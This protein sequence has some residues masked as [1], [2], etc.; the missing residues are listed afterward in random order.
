MFLGDAVCTSEVFK[1]AHVFQCAEYSLR[2]GLIWQIVGAEPA[3][4]KAPPK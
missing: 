4:W 3:A 2:S 1:F